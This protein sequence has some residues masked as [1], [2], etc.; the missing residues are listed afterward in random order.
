[1]RKQFIETGEIVKLHGVSGEIKMYPW[2]DDT[3]FV[4]GLLRVF[5]DEDGQNEMKLEKVR[6]LKNMCLLKLENI[7]TVEQAREFVGKTV[8][9]AREDV[10]LPNG[11][12]FAQDVIGCSVINEKTQVNY[13]E[14]INITHPAASDIY[15]IKNSKGDVFWFP[16]VNEFMGEIDIEN[17]TVFVKPIAGMFESIGG[18]DDA[19]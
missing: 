19:D 5:F 1:M 11:R 8:Y 12:Y 17:R 4:E 13:G 9:F 15:E 18:N 6:T 7:N 3:K 16:A 14:I 10:K 2:C